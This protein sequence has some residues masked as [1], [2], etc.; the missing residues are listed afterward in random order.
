MIRRVIYISIFVLFLSSPMPSLAQTLDKQS[1]LK[2]AL[3]NNPSYKAA[4]LEIEAAAGERSQAS[5]L[6]NPST[7]FEIENI[8]GSGQR[9]GF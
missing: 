7:V 1:A 6:P 9:E 2:Q 3:L 5:L 4:L 8:G